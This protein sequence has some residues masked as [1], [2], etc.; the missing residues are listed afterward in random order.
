MTV[1][2]RNV[3]KKWRAMPWGR[4]ALVLSLTSLTG[5]S[6]VNHMLYKTTGTVMT[7]YAEEHQVPYVLASDDLSMNCS[8]VQAPTPVL[9]SFG[10]VTHSPKQLGV[11]V[12]LSAGMC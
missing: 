3:A 4:P 5:C 11:M 9:R 1:S 7:A 12:Y 2:W 8:I 10:R 6:V